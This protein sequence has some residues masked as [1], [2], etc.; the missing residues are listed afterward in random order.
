MLD[1]MDEEII[2]QS[3]EAG[4]TM[5]TWDRVIRE[6]CGGKTPYEV[7]D[8]A[9]SEEGT[10]PEAR[11]EVEGLRQLTPSD[12]TVLREKGNETIEHLKSFISVDTLNAGLIRKLRVDE[13]YSWRAVSRALSYLWTDVDE[14]NQLAGMVLCEKAAQ[15]F[16]EDYMEPPWN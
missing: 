12:L 13:N 16:Q 1:P 15:M 14:S 10:E 2:R 7:M 6:A 4:A 5:V 8:M 11:K 3:K 9:L